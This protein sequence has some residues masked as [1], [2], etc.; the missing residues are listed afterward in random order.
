MLIIVFWK[1]Q[2]NRYIKFKHRIQKDFWVNF[3]VLLHKHNNFLTITI[4]DKF[5]HNIRQI[6]TSTNVRQILTTIN[7]RQILT[8]IN[9]HT[10]KTFSSHEPLYS[11]SL[12]EEL[13]LN[14]N[15]HIYSHLMTKHKTQSHNDISSYTT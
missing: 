12:Y 13:K 2:N 3:R 6:L 15:F 10:I 11:T 9:D 5:R 4:M 1:T 14:Y 7:A 8:T